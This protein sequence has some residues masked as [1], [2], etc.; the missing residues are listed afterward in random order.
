MAASK[1]RQVQPADGES[2]FDVQSNLD[3]DGKLYVAGDQVALG[4]DTA[5][6]L[7][8]LNVVRAAKAAA[9]KPAT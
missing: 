8:K 4:E 7:V 3:H 1:K 6:E 5:A 2:L 9:E